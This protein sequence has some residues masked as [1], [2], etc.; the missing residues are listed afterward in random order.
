MA[1]GRRSPRATPRAGAAC[2]EGLFFTAKH[3]LL[4]AYYKSAG[5]RGAYWGRGMPLW[6]QGR[7]GGAGQ[8]WRSR[9]DFLGAGAGDGM[10]G[11]VLDTRHVNMVYNTC[12][13]LF[14]NVRCQ[15]W[16]VSR[17]ASLIGGGGGR[18]AS[19]GPISWGHLMLSTIKN[20]Q[21]LS[22][23]EL[24]GRAHRLGSRTDFGVWAPTP[25]H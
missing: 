24:G 2:Q 13:T 25:R 11:S 20:M 18:R 12:K 22:V 6:E 16:A 19:F 15:R 21:L 7:F 14:D 10:A 17:D 3:C 9:A 1:V 4:S 8:V 5:S 23:I